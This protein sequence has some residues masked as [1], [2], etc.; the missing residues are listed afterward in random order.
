VPLADFRSDPVL[1]STEL[2]RITRLS[3]V[4]LTPAHY[5]R[6]LERAGVKA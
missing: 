4:P 1:K 3:V 2:V 6:V 5:A